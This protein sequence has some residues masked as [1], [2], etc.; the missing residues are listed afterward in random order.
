MALSELFMLSPSG[1]GKSQIRLWCE[2][3]PQPVSA[4]GEGTAGTSST[5]GQDKLSS[6]ENL[7]QL[8]SYEKDV[9]KAVGILV[10]TALCYVS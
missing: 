1:I 5:W 8:T 2:V 3:S 6:G 4:A 7:D 9:S 10:M